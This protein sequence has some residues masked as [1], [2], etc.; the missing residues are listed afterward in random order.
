M[1]SAVVI[2]KNEEKNIIDCLETLSFCS[3]IIVI[4]DYSQDR[5]AEIA[6]KSGAKVYTRSLDNDFSSQRNFGLD[7][8]RSYWVFFVDA[9][10]KVTPELSA[11]IQDFV[12]KPSEF[13]GAYIRRVDFMWGRKLNFGE[14]GNIEFLRLGRKGFGRWVGKVHEEWKI[15]GKLASSENYLEHFPHRTIDEFLKEINYYTDI[16][17]KELFNKGVEVSWKSIIGYPIGKFAVNYF[18]KLGILDGL[19]GFVFAIFMSFHSFLARGKLWL[20]WQKK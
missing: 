10:E 6:K 15:E 16:R 4:D 9:D 14:T 19:I 13:K 2:T 5:T 1:I 7:K 8:A 11:E 20:L 17:A 18:W 3:E 12:S